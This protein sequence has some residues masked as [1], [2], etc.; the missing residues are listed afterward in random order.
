MADYDSGRDASYIKPKFI[1]DDELRPRD[2]S[3]GMDFRPHSGQ[4]GDGGV[5]T[6]PKGHLSVDSGDGDG[7]GLMEERKM[8]EKGNRE[9]GSKS[10]MTDKKAA[11]SKRS[12][13]EA[14]GEED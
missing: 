8:G 1:P 7:E 13:A 6:G 4:W 3:G 11:M 14:D 2:N 10:V 9:G 12:K 5:V